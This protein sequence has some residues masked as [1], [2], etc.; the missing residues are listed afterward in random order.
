MRDDGRWECRVRRTRRYSPSFGRPRHE[1]RRKRMRIADPLDDGIDLRV[2][3]DALAD[4]EPSATR[5][6][7][8]RENPLPELPPPSRPF[9]RRAGAS[10]AA[11]NLD[12]G[13]KALGTF[14]WYG[15]G[16]DPRDGALHSQRAPG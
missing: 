10:I 11:M 8:A 6:L 15:I 7:P 12:G 14:P 13:T 4:L 9:G 3:C 1:R 16:L 5:R 2:E